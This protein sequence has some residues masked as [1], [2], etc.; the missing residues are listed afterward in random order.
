M[1]DFLPDNLEPYANISAKAYEHPAD[2]AATAALRAIPMLDT[3]VRKLIEWQYE[4][5]L[6]QLYLGNSIK[7]SEQQ[8]PELWTA[9]EGVSRILDMPE[10]YDL[11]V[12]SGVPG[13]AQV[14]GTGKPMIVIDS[15]LMQRLGPAEQRAVIAHELGHILSDH[16]VYVTTLNVLLSVGNG[17]PF[18]LGIPFRAVRAVLLEWYRATE[19][20]CDRAATLAVRDPRIVC[21][22]LMVTAA[23]LPVE[24]LNLDAFMTQAMEYE[25]WD[26]PSDRVRRF[27]NEIGQ[28][29][30]YAVR[31]VSEVMKWVQG[32]E[33]DRIVRG[34]YRTRDEEADVRAEAGDAFDYY[35]ERFR[36]IL[37]DAG[38]NIAKLGS[39]MG[40]MAEQ[41][42]EWI[43]ARGGGSGEN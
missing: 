14:V 22:T 27:F 29:H 42:A 4:R 10:R 7:V 13:G 11:Y 32:G 43:R 24:Q 36:T 23:G 6:R 2:R 15:D 28:T 35:A 21:T 37:Q 30:S 20:T 18:F 34:E 3:V 5:A 12:S 26:D 17:V 41:A 19:L 25:S 40:D 9:H 39:Q 1:S 38:D 8:L 31:R 16:V 33:Y